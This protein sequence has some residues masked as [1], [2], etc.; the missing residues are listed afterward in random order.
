[1]KIFLYSIAV[2]AAV[3]VGIDQ[4][5]AA[6]AN[7]STYT[8]KWP[9]QGD[10]QFSSGNTQVACPRT[11]HYAALPYRAMLAA[12]DKFSPHPVYA[13]SRH[14][15]DSTQIHEWNKF[16]STRRPWHGGYNNWR[17]NRPTALVVPPTA[18][19][20]TSYGWGV[21]QTRSLPINHQFGVTAPGGGAGSGAF[22]STPNWP[23]NT[24]Q[25]GV[26]PVRAPWSHQ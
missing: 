7:P 12:G 4:H 24:E 13:Y 10:R 2:V 18:A 14:G 21:G 17:F 3:S 19:F 16:Q 6:Q 25:F 23:Q 11:R 22:G 1:M 5:A 20:Q 26:Y 9:C 8:G 15:I